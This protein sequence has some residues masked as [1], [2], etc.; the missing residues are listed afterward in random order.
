M[1]LRVPLFGGERKRA[2]KHVPK[3]ISAC[4]RGTW[5]PGHPENAPTNLCQRHKSPGSDRER[6]IG[7]HVATI[8]CI[9][10]LDY[11]Q[12]RSDSF[13]ADFCELPRKTSHI[14]TDRSSATLNALFVKTDPL[15]LYGTT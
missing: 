11:L 6:R 3:I 12:G 14:G 4:R 5:S 2:T 1:Q 7:A 15:S 9:S 13:A 8:K 10:A